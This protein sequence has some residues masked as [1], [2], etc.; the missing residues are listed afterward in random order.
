MGPPGPT[1]SA[2]GSGPAST[3]LLHE[4][5]S[6]LGPAL[7]RGEYQPT[8]ARAEHFSTTTPLSRPQPSLAADSLAVYPVR[9]VGDA[10]EGWDKDLPYSRRRE[11][12]PW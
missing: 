5:M 8:C 4:Q 2:D 7:I 6:L 12:G 1:E 9:V 11:R 3:A 10:R